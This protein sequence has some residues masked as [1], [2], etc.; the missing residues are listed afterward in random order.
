M[1][2]KLAAANFSAKNLGK[3]ADISNSYSINY[4]V[5]GFAKTTAPTSVT[6]GSKISEIILTLQENYEMTGTATL[7]YGSTSVNATVSGSTYKWTNITPTGSVTITAKATWVGTGE[8]PEP[9]TPVNPPSGGTPSTPT[10]STVFDFDFINYKLTDYVDQGIFTVPDT[11]TI[12]SITYD[13]TKGANLNNNLPY[14][15]TLINPIDASRPWTLEF[16]VTMATPTDLTGNR[17]AFI[18]GGDDLTPFVVINGNGGADRFGFQIS[19]GSHTWVGLS[20]L[21]YDQEVTYKIVH[22]GN[23]TTTIYQNGTELGTSNASWTGKQF[24]TILGVIKGKSAAYT[25]QDVETGKK[26]YLKKFKFSYN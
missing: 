17:R 19:S 7:T 16:T 9:E 8:E 4:N 11:S 26:S 10:G 13:A 23:N 24:G 22:D 18:T 2:F 20:K 15:L 5:S 12:D 6:K 1:W 25:W 3:M 14:G 21:L